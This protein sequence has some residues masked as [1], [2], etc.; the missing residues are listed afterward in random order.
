MGLEGDKSIKDLLVIRLLLNSLEDG[1]F[2]DGTEESSATR[3]KRIEEK[4]FPHLT[5]GERRDTIKLPDEQL[6]RSVGAK[7]SNHVINLS[8]GQTARFAEGSK[9]QNKEVFAGKGCKR[10]IDEVDGLVRDYGGKASEWRKVK[11]IA[12]L[13]LPDGDEEQA[14]VHWYEEP[15]VGKVKIKRVCK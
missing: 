5:E 7:W 8:N 3:L 9:L 15:S 2:T 11:A 13:V 4:Y 12:T 10:K 6:P 1:K 14:E